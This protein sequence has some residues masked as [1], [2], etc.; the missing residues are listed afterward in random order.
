MLAE[1]LI[2]REG[3]RGKFFRGKGCEACNNTGYKGR[4][5]LFELMLMNDKLRDMIMINASA[6]DCA[7][8]LARRH[9]HPARRG[10]QSAI[11]TGPPPPKKSSAKRCSKPRRERDEPQT[12]LCMKTSDL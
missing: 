3:S 6:D 11:S 2:T 12:K 10:I 4:V 9:G 7:R 8:R 5:G 1:L